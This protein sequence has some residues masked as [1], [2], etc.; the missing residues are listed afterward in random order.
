MLAQ[1]CHTFVKVGTLQPPNLLGFQRVMS[2][3]AARLLSDARL[4][5]LA[6]RD[7]GR[8]FEVLYDRL[9]R[10]LLGFCRHMV[11]SPD[12]AEDALQQTFLRAHR[13]LL[14][15]G[16]PDDPRPWLFAIAR[17]RCKALLAARRAEAEVGEDLPA[18]A[19]L[20]D[21]V[22]ARAD[23]RAVVEDVA[24]LPD[25]QRAALVLAELADLSHAQ[26]GEVIG[27]RAGKVKALVHQARTTLIAER[28]AREQPCEEVREQIATARGAALR[29]GSLRPPAPRR[30]A[31]VPG[32]GPCG[33]APPAAP[34]A[35]R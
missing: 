19:G 28:D 14:A 10:R 6:A 18:T 17:T 12:E 4:A 15:H 21:E 8:A 27:V 7:G 2:L 20:A 35:T 13:A 31:A 23:L 34:T 24:R 32:A 25:N 3:R 29:R 16:A 9:H 1:P 5:Q 22:Q 11:G 26:I 33:C 30:G